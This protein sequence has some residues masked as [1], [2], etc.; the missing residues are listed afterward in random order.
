L[1]IE[2][3]RHI[4]RLRVFIGKRLAAASRDR[5]RIGTR[6]PAVW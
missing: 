2:G 5:Q 6:G 3:F 1:L 4:M